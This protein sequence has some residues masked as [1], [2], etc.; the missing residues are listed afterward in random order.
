MDLERLT[1]LLDA[2]TGRWPQV[3]AAFGG[4]ALAAGLL[5][6]LT[7]ALGVKEDDGLKGLRGRKDGP[8]A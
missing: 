2:L 7:R 3:L 8:S 4:A 5:G 1:A 6:A